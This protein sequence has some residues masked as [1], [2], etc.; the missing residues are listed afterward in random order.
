MTRHVRIYYAALAA[1]TVASIFASRARAQE[2]RVAPRA[3]IA[4]QVLDLASVSREGLDVRARTEPARAAAVLKLQPSIAAAAFPSCKTVNAHLSTVAGNAQPFAS[5]PN[6]GSTGCGSFV[7]DYMIPAGMR[8]HE[9][10]G[11]IGLGAGSVVA[12]G[13]VTLPANQNDCN[14]YEEEARYWA[15]APVQG[16]PWEFKYVARLEG[17]WTSGMC[18]LFAQDPDSRYA[19]APWNP[20][21]WTYILRAAIEARVGNTPKPIVVRSFGLVHSHPPLPYTP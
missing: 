14:A 9:D 2:T 16:S 17:R 4:P 7:I 8:S 10:Y 20:K 19:H 3:T 21:P 11:A 1:L 6:Y 15:R 5:P 18:R 13:G 12:Y